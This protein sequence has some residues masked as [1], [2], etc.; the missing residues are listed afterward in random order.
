MLAAWRG[1]EPQ[2]SELIKATLQEAT[3]RGLGR[4]AAVANYAS[5]VLAHRRPRRPQDLAT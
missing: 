5:S 2:A 1:E 4:I 3:V